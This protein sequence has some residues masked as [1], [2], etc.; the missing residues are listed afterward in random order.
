[1]SEEITNKDVYNE[2]KSLSTKVDKIYT[3]LFGDDGMGGMTRTVIDLQSTVHGVKDS[4]H[5]IGLVGTIHHICNQIE[6][7]GTEGLKAK[8][9]SF[10]TT[11]DR[12]RL[13]NL[14]LSFS[15]AGTW[16]AGIFL[17]ITGLL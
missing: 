11:K 6:G 7:N 4:A 2:L 14:G 1:M 15:Q 13:L 3:T 8:I 16:L 12:Q 17:K 5:D 9:A 10:E